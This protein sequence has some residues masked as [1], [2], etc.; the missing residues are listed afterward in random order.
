MFL[1]INCCLHTSHFF[2]KCLAFYSRMSGYVELFCTFFF[3]PLFGCK[4]K[5]FDTAVFAYPEKRE[6][7]QDPDIGFLRQRVQAKQ[8]QSLLIFDL[9]MHLVQDLQQQSF[10]SGDL[11]Q[12]ILFCPVVNKWCILSSH[13]P[14]SLRQHLVTA[15][16]RIKSQKSVRFI[17]D[18]A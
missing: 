9:Q 12:I 16:L 8:Q 7:L 13:C 18:S 17:S 15:C 4:K 10:P 2:I 5:S 1:M 11:E 6:W 14:S 3:C